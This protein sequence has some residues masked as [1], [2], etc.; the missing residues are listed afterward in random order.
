MEKLVSID[1]YA[2]FGMLKKPD[3]NEPICLTF[4]MLHK[5]ALLGILGAILGLEGF[6]E[7]G[8]LPKYYTAL[9]D[10]R[11]GIEPLNHE[12][13][14]F[15]K[16]IIKY[17]NSTGLASKETGGNLILTEQ[18]LISPGYRC[19]LLLNMNDPL[20]NRL[21]D[22]L[23]NNRAE[24]IPYI[25]KNEFSAWWENYSHYSDIEEVLNEDEYFMRSIFIKSAPLEDNK[26][27]QYF[28]PLLGG[29]LKGNTF[30]YFEHLPIGYDEELFQYRYAD[31]AFTDWLLESMIESK[32]SIY[33]VNNDAC[34]QLF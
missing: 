22:Y 19:Y 15:K 1:L 8:K 10:L 5:P 12:N 26:K 16:S 14:N 6:K 4:N 33:K 34:I 17:N 31:F 29:S 13:G 27:L 20:Q 25:G 32:Y 9:I 28:N 3:T 11:V 21:D 30:S 24:F 18:T 2:D 23:S 7:R